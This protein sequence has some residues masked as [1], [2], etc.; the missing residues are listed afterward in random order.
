M[1]YHRN[2]IGQLERGEKSPS[3]NALFNFA[4]GLGLRPS[5]ML[6]RVEQMITDSKR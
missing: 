1:G 6:S 5:E 3:L 4:N 2:Y